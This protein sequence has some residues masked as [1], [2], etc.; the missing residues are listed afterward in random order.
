MKILIAED[1]PVS[2]RLLEALLSR[3]GYDVLVA[4]D[5]GEAWEV[6]QG[7]ESPSLVISDWMMSDMDGLD[8]CRS[9]REKERP[10]YTYFIILTAKGRKEELKYRVKIGERLVVAMANPLVSTIPCPSSQCLP[11]SGGS[12]KWLHVDPEY[13]E[14]CPPMEGL[15]RLILEFEIGVEGELHSLQT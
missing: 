3:Y 8:L 14:T 7:P 13:P 6:L 10:G 12:D 9:I 1:D 15:H 5:G 4:R 2:R 11:A